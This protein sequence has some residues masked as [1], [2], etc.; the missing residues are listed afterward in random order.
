MSILKIKPFSIDTAELFT[1]ANANITSNL[2]SGNANLG[3]LAT[4][5]YF[6][7]N[8][9]GLTSI[10]GANVSGQVGNALIS[11]TVYTAAQPNITSV[12]TLTSLTVSGNSDFG[13][14]ANVK[15]TG[16]SNGYVLKT[17]GSGNL[18]WIAA[19]SGTGNANVGGSNTQVQF[20]NGTNLAGSA[21]LTFDTT[22]NT[23]S[24]TN[25]V[26][27]GSQLTGVAA[28]SA[29]KTA[30]GTSNVDIATASGNITMGVGGTAGVVTITTTGIN[31]NGYITAS[32]NVTGSYILGNG[33]SLTSITGANV[34]GAVSYASTAN[35]VA[36]ANVSGAV[37]LATFAGTANAVAG[38]NVTGAV[39][40]ATFAGTANAVAGANVSGEVAF[41]ATANSVAGAN[42]TGNVG[43]ALNAYAVAGANVSGQVANALV[44]GTVYTNAQPNITSVGTLTSL[45]VTGNLTTGNANITGTL[46]VG[47]ITT[48]A[49]GSGNISGAD[50]ISANAFIASGNINAAFYF[51]NGSQLSGVSAA[52]AQKTANGT[53]NV[54]ISTANGNITMGV[55][56]NAGIVTVTGTGVNVAGY[57]TTTGNVTVGNII[58]NGQALTGLAG[59]NVTGAVAFATTANAVAG[60]NVSGQVGNALVAGT[61]YTN[62]QPNITSVGTL[63]SLAV[64]GTLSAGDTT[65]AGNLTVT[66]TTTSVNSTVTQIVD[67]IFELGG[68][69]NGAALATNDGKERGQLMHYYDGGVK[70]AFMGWMNTDKVFTF[71]SN[72]SVANNNVTIT[73]LGNIKAGDANLG[74]AVTSNYFVGN[75]SLLTGIIASGGTATKLANGTSN[76]DVVTASGN[77]TMGVGGTGNV[78][79]VTGTGIN[80]AGTINATGNLTAANANLGNLATANFFTGNGS[81]LTSITGANVTGNVGN[82][83]NAYAVAGANVSGAV[84]FATTANSVAGANVS[85]AVGLATFAGTANAV[86]GANVSGEV[87]FAATANAVAG[88]NVSGQVG[89]ALVAGTVYTAAQPNIT[90]TGTLTSLTVS[91]VTTLGAVANVKI[92]G[93]SADYVLKTD[94]SGNLSWTALSSTTL[95]VD[96]FIGD[97]SWTMKTLSA[98][99]ASVDYTIV[100]I[101]GVLQPRNTYSVL[102]AVITFSEAPPTSAVVEITTVTGGTGGGGGG[103]GGVSWTYSAVSANTTMVASYKYIVD[104]S[105]ANIT[106]TLPSSGTLGDEIT[107]IDGTGNASTRAITVARNGG[108]IQGSASDMTVTTDRAAFTLAYYNST[109]GWLLTNV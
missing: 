21:N 91:G 12:G 7:G 97:G 106:M 34:T 43:N 44:A 67:P 28:A 74:N 87:S 93:G 39:G 4:A 92:S 40:L 24:A 60:A 19:S 45:A 48:S 75:G 86:A 88:G 82:A 53:S 25:F 103:G 90:S 72:V 59:A 70:D 95:V 2:V 41:A 26:G 100:A 17:D 105:S 1:F 99:P 15:I 83:L 5:N 65:I 107:I 64:T 29:T 18:S 66:G 23:L 11:G 50:V 73:T 109:Q 96:R 69:A 36:G 71:A 10:A 32:G 79:I 33:S 55:G 37:G 101:G 52:T 30:N 104:T 54:D 78:V 58:G 16:G 61:V 14:V 22:T 31:A 68:G 13:A 80:V 56:G 3:N 42:V 63:T 20:N 94:G 62:A 51:G 46:T 102:A 89:N 49:G 35:S 85:G 84:A 8:G 57:I 27:N 77:I 47:A 76:V 108:K 9:S 6:S 98:T 81:L 38:A